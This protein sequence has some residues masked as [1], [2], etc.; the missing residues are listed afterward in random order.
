MN[1]IQ[2]LTIVWEAAA[3]VGLVVF[4][5]LTLR[6]WLGWRRLKRDG[7]IDERSWRVSWMD[8]RTAAMLALVMADHTV[9]GIFANISV[10]RGDPPFSA[11]E[12]WAIAHIGVVF[13]YGLIGS[14]MMLLAVGLW[15]SYDLHQLNEGEAT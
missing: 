1:E 11:L 2:I 13:R 6:A 8:G 14:V 4:A 10:F 5:W 3:F 9:L 15:I 7:V 12:Q